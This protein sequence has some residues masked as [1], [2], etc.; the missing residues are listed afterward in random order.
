MSKKTDNIAWLMAQ[1]CECA[2]ESANQESRITTLGQ[3]LA[4]AQDLHQQDIGTAGAF[5][6]PT[7]AHVERL[8]A[9]VERLEHEAAAA[10]LEVAEIQRRFFALE[11]GRAAT[12]EPVRLTDCGNAN[13]GCADSDAPPERWITQP[14]A[15]AAR[16]LVWALVDGQD[17]AYLRVNAA[18]H[19]DRWPS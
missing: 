17:L 1:A 10:A 7:V 2:R 12:P 6:A 14:E 19:I 11:G 4:A 9:R 8:V 15:Y 16:A 18:A 13:C 5:L 3:A